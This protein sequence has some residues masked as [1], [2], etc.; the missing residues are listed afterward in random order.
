MFSITEY[1]KIHS[2]PVYFQKMY[3][4]CNK[5]DKNL[6]N[7]I[8]ITNRHLIQLARRLR[9][10]IVVTFVLKTREEEESDA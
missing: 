9:G 8:Q 4:Y 1:G 10:A 7:H 6:K 5:C 2:N 3:E